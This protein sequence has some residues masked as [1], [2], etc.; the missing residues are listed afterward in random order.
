MLLSKNRTLQKY[1][2]EAHSGN[3]ISCMLHASSREVSALQPVGSS[4]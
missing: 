1:S 2:V 3:L 4:H